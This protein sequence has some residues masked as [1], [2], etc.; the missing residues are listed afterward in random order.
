MKKD[1]TARAI[2]KEVHP[3]NMTLQEYAYKVK[4]GNGSTA[5]LSSTQILYPQYNFQFLSDHDYAS[6]AQDLAGELCYDCGLDL[7][8]NGAIL[9]FG[10]SQ[11]TVMHGFS[12]IHKT[13]EYLELGTREGFK[14][15]I[16]RSLAE[17]RL[18]YYKPFGMAMQLSCEDSGLSLRDC[19]FFN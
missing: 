9:V 14:S 17:E 2:I 11:I 3:S 5:M 1:N 19:F 15:K 18:M 8:R 10:E 4:F 13:Y 6:F 16:R 12:F 7:L